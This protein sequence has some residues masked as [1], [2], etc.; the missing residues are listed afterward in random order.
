MC[1]EGTQWWQSSCSVIS[2]SVQWALKPSGKH[3]VIKVKLDVSI[4][5]DKASPL[6][7]T[8][9]LTL[10][11]NA[12][13][14]S[15][16]SGAKQHLR[17]GHH[18]SAQDTNQWPKCEPPHPKPPT[19][20]LW[21][22]YAAWVS[23]PLVQTSLVFLVVWCHPLYQVG[24]AWLLPAVTAWT[25]VPYAAAVSFLLLGCIVILVV[26]S[27]SSSSL[28][29]GWCTRNSLTLKVSSCWEASTSEPSCSSVL[30]VRG[31]VCVGGGVK[32]DQCATS[33][34]IPTN[35]F[36]SYLHLYTKTTTVWF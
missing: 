24:G 1:D 17:R 16:C 25:W 8:S 32:K 5:K 9:C 29:L 2:F 30:N 20:L 6:T 15:S 11:S 4:L 27:W 19:H 21:W 35:L 3:L 31:S 18:V 7:P 33:T 14:R 22:W 23:F 26:S 12:P 28:S 34:E 13:I 36:S 10:L